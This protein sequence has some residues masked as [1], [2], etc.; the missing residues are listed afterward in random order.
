MVTGNYA[1]EYR[2]FAGAHVNCVLR[3]GTNAFHG[4]AWEHL[5][6]TELNARN[7]FARTA[8]EADASADQFGALFSGPIRRNSTFFML[9]GT[10]R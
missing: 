9:I 5:E 3:S 8:A 2:Q 1:A 7:F 4:N 6:N 10:N